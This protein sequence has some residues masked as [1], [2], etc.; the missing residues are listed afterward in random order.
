MTSPTIDS[1]CDEFESAARLTHL[2]LVTACDADEAHGTHDVVVAYLRGQDLGEIVKKADPLPVFEAVDAAQ[3]AHRDI[4]SSTLLLNDNET[5]VPPDSR[6]QVTEGT[7]YSRN[8]VRNIL[9]RC[10]P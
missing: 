10:T 2:N 6:V 4:K 1:L 9:E 8:G 3:W 7:F 5:V